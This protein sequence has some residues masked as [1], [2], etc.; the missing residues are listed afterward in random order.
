M[1][2]DLLHN[3]I[4]KETITE[5]FEKSVNESLIPKLYALYSTSLEGVQMYEDYLNDDFNK[6]GYWYYPLTVLIAGINAVIW[7]KWDVSDK[8]KFEG[9]NPYAYVGEGIDFLIA[10]DV[11]MAFKNAIDGR[12]SYFEGGCVKT[13]VVTDAPSVSIL[14]GKYSQTFIDEMTRQI[15]GVIEK[16]CGVSG[17]EN[18]SIELDFVFAPNTYMEHTSENVT[19]RRLLISAKGCAPRDFW[20]KWTRQNSSVAFSVND[21]VSGEDIIFELG[22][23]VPHKTREKEY[24]FLVYGNS[25]KYRVAMGRKNITEWRELIKRA[26]KRGE[27]NKTTTELEKDAHVSEVSDK[28]SEILEKYGMAI[29]KAPE[30][31][32]EGNAD[33]ANEALRLAV[34][35]DAPEA[36]FETFEGAD[37]EQGRDALEKTEAAAEEAA[38][39]TEAAESVISENTDI[40]EESESV[41]SFA[42][43]EITDETLGSDADE[44]DFDKEHEQF[45]IEIAD[46]EESSFADILA[47][48]VP[49][50][51]EVSESADEAELEDMTVAM[52][53]EDA[54]IAENA[55]DAELVAAEELLLDDNAETEIN[56]EIEEAEEAE[57]ANDG[58]SYTEEATE[59]APAY[60]AEEIKREL[61]AEYLEKISALNSELDVARAEIISARRDAESARMAKENAENALNSE[62]L[63]SADLR[64]EIEKQ[65]FAIEQVRI[66]IDEAANA[67]MLAEAETARVRAE[68]EELKRENA[69]LVEAARAAEEACA[70]A[71]EK[72]R[73]CEEKLE[74]QIELFEKEKIRQKNLFA[75]AAR[76]AKEESE[77]TE[78]ELAEAEALRRIEEARLEAIRAEDNQSNASDTSLLEARARIEAEALRRMEEAA[79]RKKTIE[80]RAYEARMRMEERARAAAEARAAASADYARVAPAEAAAVNAAPTVQTVA[81][82]DEAKDTYVPVTEPI[83]EPE[84][85][86]VV[87]YT[88]TSKLVRLLFSRSMDPNVTARIHELIN[89]ALNKFGKSDI[90]I[91]VKAG[92]A[93]N[94]TV[95]L[96]FVEFPEEEFE[97]L[98]DIIKYLGNSD[99]GIYKIILD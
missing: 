68:Y 17:I 99:L 36:D 61:E 66:L 70:V 20:I 54:A 4:V 15:T 73:A 32:V 86:P 53:D 43:L 23:D 69:A 90:Y 6:D 10:D 7:I 62:R 38:S 75:E 12:S 95:V 82:D 58:I 80:E 37:T 87:N 42:G 39:V 84:P 77:R 57:K 28:L 45:E 8:S 64:V 48:F 94:S 40:A 30:P 51:D 52:D 93:D 50:D 46:S 11:P 18:S 81:E 3:K 96:N 27:L 63:S 41:F 47:D 29:P 83:S 71:E 16:A 35:G 26:V 25:E 78:A 89:E 13:N 24:R 59:A 65:K 44:F 92:I 91:K 5:A 49:T 55:D 33:K 98:V 85:K 56:E 74:E 9:G 97:L 67:R 72:S 31:E 21:N 60:D 2:V 34:L 1:I 22:E 76:Q 14:I 19:Y 88:Y 79:E